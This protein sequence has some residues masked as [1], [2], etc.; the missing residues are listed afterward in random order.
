M[1]KSVFLQPN[2]GYMIAYLTGLFSHK[3]PAL[4]Y[5]D[6]N[7]VGYEVHISLN[8]YGAIQN[9]EKGT[10]YTYLQIKEDSHTLYGFADMEEK[11]MFIRLIGINGVGASTARMMLSSMRPDEITK[12]I[13][14]SNTRLLESIKGIGKKTAERIVLELKDKLGKG[15]AAV[16]IG[17][18]M[19]ADTKEQ[20]ALQ[21]LTAL[22]IPRQAAETA[23]KKVMG[24]GESL[25]LEQLIK[26]ALQSI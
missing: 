18:P 8:T 22:G 14:Q 3:S 12:A 9:Q 24:S 19:T 6:I 1:N 15:D 4:V 11:N 2:F 5:V 16:S 7:G 26:K 21:A 13:I 25:D 20:D 23:V 10:L 17:A